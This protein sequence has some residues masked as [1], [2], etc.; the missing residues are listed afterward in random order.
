MENA[1]ASL[2]AAADAAMNAN[3]GAAGSAKTTEAESAWTYSKSHDDVRNG[4]IVTASA[5][6]SNSINLDFPYAGGTWLDTTVR[7]HPA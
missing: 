1:A 5:R 7:K 3:A 6:S 2:D 4:D